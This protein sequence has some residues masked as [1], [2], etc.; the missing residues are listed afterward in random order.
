MIAASYFHDGYTQSGFIAA[1]PRMHGALRFTYRPALVEERSQLSEVARQL[2]PHLYDRHA[3]AFTA[4]KIVS[5]SLVDAHEAAV[6]VSGESLLRLQPDLFIK[7]HKIVSGWIPSDIDPA[8]PPPSRD[9]ALDDELAAAVADRPIGEVR[10]RARR[11]KLLMG[12]NLLLFH[13]QLIERTCAR[14][15]TWM[16]DDRHRVVTR[17]GQPIRRPP[18]SPTPCWQCPKQSPDRATGCERDLERIQRTLRL[19]FDVRATA[20]R[21]LT[22]REAADPLLARNLSMVDMLVRRW[23]SSQARALHPQSPNARSAGVSAS[24]RLRR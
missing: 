8:W 9:R 10:R 21:V 23:E 18:G 14:C 12:V 13:P 17:L 3:A 6:P 19:Y 22:E 16:Y 24:M 5:W 20:G 4:Q 15:R 7:L 2:K 11:K 1:V